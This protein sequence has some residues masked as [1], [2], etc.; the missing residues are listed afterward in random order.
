MTTVLPIAVKE[1][2]RVTSISSLLKTF[3]KNLGCECFVALRKQ[4]VPR[5]PPRTRNFLHT[6]MYCVDR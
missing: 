4:A 1:K 5:H 3:K 6:H 2:N